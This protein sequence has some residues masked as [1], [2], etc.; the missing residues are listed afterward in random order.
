MFAKVAAITGRYKCAIYSDSGGVPNR[1]LRASAEVISAGTG[2]QTFPLTSSLSLTNGQYYWLAIWSDDSGAQIYYSGTSG[3]I[4]WGNYPYGTWPDP[5]VTTGSASVQ[6]CIYA[7]GAAAAPASIAGGTSDDKAM[8]SVVEP[9]AVVRPEI[10]SISV[11]SGLVTISSSALEG[12]TYVL[13]YVENLGDKWVQVPS[14]VTAT[15]PTV[16]FTDAAGTTSTRFY[17]VVQFRLQE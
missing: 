11:E 9:P 14:F 1:L 15:G 5:F 6:Y 2:W 7:A 3:T 4:R 8:L 17:R 10:S 12:R 13:E 16:T